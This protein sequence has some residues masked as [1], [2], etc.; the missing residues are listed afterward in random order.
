[1]AFK[2]AVD[3][4]TI[5]RLEQKTGGLAVGFREFISQYGV[6]PLA[7]GVVIGTS[8]NDFVKT[9]V[10]GLVSP[11]VA[12]LSPGGKLQ[13]L[14]WVFHGSVFKVGAILNSLISLVIICLIVYV[15]AKLILRNEE[16]LKKK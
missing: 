5:K 14:Q 8:I 10:D 1:M 9:L 7:I 6:G 3:R 15:F 13:T 12:L 4:A 16:L 11:L 2:P